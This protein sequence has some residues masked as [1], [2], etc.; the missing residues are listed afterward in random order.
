MAFESPQSTEVSKR[1]LDLGLNPDIGIVEPNLPTNSKPESLKIKNSKRASKSHS[2]KVI[3][4]S[5]GL[6]QSFPSDAVLDCSRSI[7]DLPPVLISEI[8]NCLDPKELGIVSCVSTIFHRAAAEHHAWKEF[9]CER[10]GLPAV[11]AVL[12][13][14]VADEK[15][16]RELFV[17]REFRSRTFMGRYSMDVLYGHT[18]AVRTVFL[19]ASAKLIFTSGYDSVVRMWDMEDGLSIASSRPLG[20]T[21]RAVAADRRLLIAGG[22]DGFIHCWRAVEGLPHL[23]ELR[24]TQMQNTEFRLW[25]HEGPITSLALDLTRIYSGSWDMTV[26]LWDRHS[27]KCTKVLGHSDW[28]WGL[29]PHDTTVAST[30]GSDVYV[31]DISSGNLTTIIHNAH[32]GNT[33]ALAR[34]H[35]GDFLF[36]GGEDGAIHMYEIMNDDNIETRAWQIAS[37]IPHT[38]PVYSLA[39]EFP[40]VVSASSDGKLSLIDVRKLLRTSKRALGKRVS[41]VMHLDRSTVEP[42]QRMLH[43]FKNNLFSVDIGADRIVCGGEE[44]VVRIWNFTQ[45]LEI[46]RRVRA[47]RGIRLENRMRRRKLQTEVS[48][49]GG[50]NDQCSVAAKKNS[51]NGIWPSK[52]GVSGKLKA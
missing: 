49:K 33:Y 13:S 14:G 24:G 8:L 15:S 26:R 16:W 38:G 44:G 25:G 40:W 41:K 19:L 1:L 42:P 39:F 20:C 12:D 23:F 30:S 3:A 22:T 21:I 29:V 37:W 9:Y 27:L 50:R 52:R 11:P 6:N 35:T 7:T 51:V 2:K 17:E 31:W 32:V 36:T 45:A 5:S 43:G 18:E 4:T 28:V 34:S 48:N 10:W 47:L 46:E